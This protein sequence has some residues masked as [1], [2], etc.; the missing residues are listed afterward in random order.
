MRKPDY[1]RRMKYLKLIA[2][3]FL[4][5]TSYEVLA[6]KIIAP[7]PFTIVRKDY[8]RLQILPE[9]GDRPAD[10]VFFDV[11][12]NTGNVFVTRLDS[13]LACTLPLNGFNDGVFFVRA[14]I[15]YNGF[16]DSIGSK[17]DRTGIPV[18]LDRR[19]AYNEKRFSSLYTKSAKKREAYFASGP[20]TQFICN[21]NKAEFVSAWDYD[22]LYCRFVIRDLHLNYDKEGF[23]DLFQA[24]GFLQTLWY[25]DCVEI[26]FDMLQNRSEWK[27]KDDYELLV[28]VAG[29]HTSNRW[30]AADSLYEHW[31]RHARITVTASGT[32]NDN[33][34]MDS[35]YVVNIAIPWAELQY[36]PEEG[37]SIGFDVQ[38]YDKDGSFDEAFRT[39]ISG[40][41]PESNDNTSEWTSLVLEKS[42]P[43]YAWLYIGG[44]TVLSSIFIASMFYRRKINPVHVPEPSPVKYSEGISKAIQ[45]IADHYQDANLSRGEIASHV[46]LSEKYISAL[47]KKEVGVNL[48]TYINKYRVE[49]SVE[50]LQNTRLSVSEIAFKVGYNSVQNFNKNFKAIVLRSPSDFRK[51]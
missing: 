35:G 44:S 10:S 3:S 6:Y 25:S 42:S 24:K 16:C 30:S 45:Y 40:T 38:F 20:G 41:N 32:P 37:K 47:F 22:S 50:M 43:S 9:N 12:Y 11:F 39:S 1:L 51:P 13:S 36:R 19:P 14:R 31:S 15:F 21:N 17:Y 7:D 48:V 28:D 18:V 29:R 8:I 27:D 26:D 4:L 49:K 23:I 5:V 33:H 46:F 34:D 2:V